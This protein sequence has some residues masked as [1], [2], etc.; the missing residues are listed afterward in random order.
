MKKAVD[1]SQAKTKAMRAAPMSPED[2][3]QWIAVEAIP[4]FIEYGTSV[5]TKQ[6]A[7]HLG[8]AEGTIFR[9]FPDKESLIKAVA[10]AFF[11]QAHEAVTADLLS[12]HTDLRETL[13]TIIRATREFSRGVFRMLSLLDHD[14]A[15][16]IIKHQDNRCFE[17]TVKQALAP[18]SVQLNLPSDRLG[19]L[20]KLVVVAASAPRLS[21][22]VPLSDEEMLDFLLYGMIGQT[23]SDA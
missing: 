7:D 15:H 12:N 5:T 16:E 4:L 9:A 17:D 20:I 3:R 18:Y 13:L 23:G 19:V 6:L 22:S 10:E 14:E 1:E 2:R 21:S 8:I 11:I